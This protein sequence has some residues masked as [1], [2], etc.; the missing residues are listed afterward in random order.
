MTDQEAITCKTKIQGI[1]KLQ[2][3]DLEKHVHLQHNTASLK[4]AA[5]I[6][7]VPFYI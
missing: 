3:K 1:K 7:L 5:V 2:M 4:E 6:F